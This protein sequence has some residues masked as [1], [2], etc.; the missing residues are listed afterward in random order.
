MRC[1]NQSDK[2][3]ERARRFDY[4][5]L[6]RPAGEHPVGAEGVVCDDAAVDEGWVIIELIDEEGRRLPAGRPRSSR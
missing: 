4:V 1:M 2:A 5:R 6:M 3:A